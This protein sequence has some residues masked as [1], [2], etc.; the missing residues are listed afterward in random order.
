MHRIAR[1]PELAAAGVAAVRRELDLPDPVLPVLRH[2]SVEE[3]LCLLLAR[4][5]LHGSLED[6]DAAT[7]WR[8]RLGD[9]VYLARFCIWRDVEDGLDAKSGTSTSRN[10]ETLGRAGLSRSV[11]RKNGKIAKDRASDLTSDV[12]L[13]AE[14]H[15]DVGGDVDRLSV[16][17]RGLERPGFGRDQ[18]GRDELGQRARDGTQILKLAGLVDASNE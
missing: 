10:R 18:R 3:E 6:L 5:D 7:L 17:R 14:A 16:P 11:C 1:E 4:P 12:A 15:R 2:R 9:C 13:K 8:H